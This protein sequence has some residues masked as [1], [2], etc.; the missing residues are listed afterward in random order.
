MNFLFIILFNKYFENDDLNDKNMQ[1]LSNGV[2]LNQQF[3]QPITD[4]QKDIL[5][6]NFQNLLQKIILILLIY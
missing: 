3:K 1:K 2:M 5:N 6:N 4:D